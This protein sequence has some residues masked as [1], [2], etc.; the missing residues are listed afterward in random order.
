M[1]PILA[2]GHNDRIKNLAA[3]G[4]SIAGKTDP[5]GIVIHILE[6]FGHHVSTASW[7]IHKNLHC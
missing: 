6:Y 7:A 1:R 3:N 2:V 5:T 4:A